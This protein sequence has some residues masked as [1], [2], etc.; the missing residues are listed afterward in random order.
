[1]TYY[2]ASW[3]TDG[4]GLENSEPRSSQKPLVTEEEVNFRFL[5]DV[6]PIAQKDDIWKMCSELH[7]EDKAFQMINLDLRGRD[8]SFEESANA[9]MTDAQ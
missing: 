4:P 7:E 9:E 5:R 3:F 1:M 6:A 2:M 8:R